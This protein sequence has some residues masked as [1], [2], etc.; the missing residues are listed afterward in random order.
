M[1]SYTDETMSCIKRTKEESRRILEAVERSERESLEFRKRRIK[2]CHVGA[3]VDRN[4]LDRIEAYAKK[5]GKSL[6]STVR[7]LIEKGLKEE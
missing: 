1:N 4:T 7:E 2:N 3:A 6:S 5:R